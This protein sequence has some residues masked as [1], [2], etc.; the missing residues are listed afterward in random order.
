MEKNLFNS[1]EAIIFDMDGLMLNS[2]VIFHQAWQTTLVDLGYEHLDDEAY[3]QLVGCSN[4][5]AETILLKLLGADFPIERFRSGW[6]P[7]WEALAAQGIPTK[8]GLWPLLDWLDETG[9]PKAV[10]TASNEHEAQICL[11]ST[12]L[13]PRFDAIVTVD[14]AG[15][16]KPAPDIFLTAADA[17]KVAP[18]RCLVLEDSNAGVQAA[19]AA[20]MRV[21]MVP[22]LQTPTD[23]ARHHALRIV[24]SL[25]EVLT[26]LQKNSQTA[27]RS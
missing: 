1:P 27:A 26:Y 14:Q 12:G 13:W 15:A 17:L 6:R 25:H 19:V 24:S 20:D 4:D 16:G 18:S 2:E 10:G 23:Y 11:R 7:R 8:P 9:L 5:L 3:L 21:I 22:D